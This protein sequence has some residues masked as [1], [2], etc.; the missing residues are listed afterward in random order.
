LAAANYYVITGDKRAR[1]AVCK[2]CDFVV[3]TQRS[4][5]GFCYEDEPDELVYY[6]DHAACFSV[7]ALESVMMLETVTT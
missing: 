4:E 2:F 5:G 1:E 3:E 7:W 6:V